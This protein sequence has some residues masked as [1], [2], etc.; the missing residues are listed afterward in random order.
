MRSGTTETGS[1]SVRAPFADLTPTEWA[2]LHSVRHGMSD[3]LI[4]LNRGVSTDGIRFH[5]RN[6]KSKLGIERREELRFWRD[7]REALGRSDVSA[8]R[9]DGLAQVSQPVTDLARAVAFY[10]DVLRLPLLYPVEGPIAFFAIGETR[11][12]LTSKG[13][14]GRFPGSVLYLHVADIESAYGTF[15]SRGVTM[16]GAPHVI[17]TDANG[18]ET[19]LAFFEDPDGN[20]LALMSEVAP[21]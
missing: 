15:S 20:L 6:I 21:E 1:A 7:P 8:L 14:G 3:R 4:A 13:G 2:V 11:L 5:V 17:H 10:G 18:T 16:R 9:I 12:M 19:W